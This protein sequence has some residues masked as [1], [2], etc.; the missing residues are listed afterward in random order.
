VRYSKGDLIIDKY[1]SK[2]YTVKYMLG[3]CVVVNSG[4]YDFPIDC[5]AVLLYSS[6]IKELM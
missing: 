5:A 2:V 1:D 4:A 3:F 6:L